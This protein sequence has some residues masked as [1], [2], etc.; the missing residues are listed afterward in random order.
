MKKLLLAAAL[1]CIAGAA[2]AETSTGPFWV[3][4]LK[5]SCDQ[6]NGIWWQGM[7]G[8]GHF[9]RFYPSREETQ[10]YEV[11]DKTLIVQGQ[12]CKTE[13]YDCALLGISAPG[14]ET[15]GIA[16]PQGWPQ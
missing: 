8:G 5:V 12:P 10:D 6:K 15:C 3:S 13:P 2:Q 1:A 4:A 14:K 9:I 16:L 7:N 11:K